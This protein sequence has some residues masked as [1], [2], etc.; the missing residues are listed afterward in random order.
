MTE[1]L[2]SMVGVIEAAKSSP[3]ALMALVV[4]LAAWVIA[5]LQVK[6]SARALA[7]LRDLPER[8]RLRALELAMG[9]VPLKAKLSPEQWLRN[10]IYQY[11]FFA[12]GLLCLVV[13]LLAAM[14]QYSA[15]N[16]FSSGASISLHTP[17]SVAPTDP[18][19]PL[20]TAAAQPD[21]T[22]NAPVRTAVKSQVRRPASLLGR[23]A[24]SMPWGARQM[25]EDNVPP[26]R[27]VTYVDNLEDGIQHVRYRADY[28]QQMEDG[29]RVQGYNPLGATFKWRY[30]ELAIDIVNNEKSTMVLSKAILTVERSSIVRTPVLLVQDDSVNDLVIRNEGWADVEG[31]Q[32]ELSI[33]QFA[34]G[35][36][37]DLFAPVVRTVRL[38]PFSEAVRIPLQPLLPARLRTAG[39]VSV[40]GVIAYTAGDLHRSIHFD[41]HVSLQVRAAAGIPASHTY[42]T[43][44]RAGESPVQIAVDLAQ[45][46][47]PGSADRFYVQL[48][49]DKTS[50]SVM[51]IDFQTPGG[52]I[53]SGGR[54][55]LDIFVPRSAANP[56]QR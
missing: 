25:A 28:L 38:E 55:K 13:L 17:E 26:D 32:V 11:S 29:G 1:L 53:L 36:S 23:I 37:V 24:V 18:A 31:G 51:R 50:S 19:P 35:D 39:R 40:S 46:I 12:F 6:K 3:L 33:Q 47:A 44:F 16:A 42:Q 4:I 48:G 27:T 14:A 43:F 49:T 5:A 15:H 2:K 54:I 56:S 7:H 10:R 20:K 45:Q 34:A 22:T 8:D 52:E 9:S 41:T 30:P 21:R